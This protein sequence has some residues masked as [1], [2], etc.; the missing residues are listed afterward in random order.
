LDDKFSRFD[1]IPVHDRQTDRRAPYDSKYGAWVKTVLTS[2]E[3]RHG[4]LVDVVLVH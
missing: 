3:K 2:D 1:T 4:M